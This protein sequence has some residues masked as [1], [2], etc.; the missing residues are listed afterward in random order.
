MITTDIFTLR[1]ETRS[2][3]TLVGRSEE[4]GLKEK[5]TIVNDLFIVIV[6]SRMIPHYRSVNSRLSDHG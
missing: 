6:G 5:S 1:S 4:Y 3:N 2:V